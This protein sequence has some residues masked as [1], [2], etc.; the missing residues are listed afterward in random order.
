MSS[1]MILRL[2]MPSKEW[3]EVKV[4]AQK[5]LGPLN[6]I[7]NSI[8]SMGGNTAAGIYD[9]LVA[10]GKIDTDPLGSA[11]YVSSIRNGEK[12]L[13]RIKSSR[14]DHMKKSILYRMI[15]DRIA[16]S[17]NCEAA[18][19]VGKLF[20]YAVDQY[21]NIVRNQSSSR[22]RQAYREKNARLFGG[23]PRSERKSRSG[24]GEYRVPPAPEPQGGEGPPSEEEQQMADLIARAEAAEV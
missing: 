10:T 14:S 24:G 4:C 17:K 1:T 2:R 19:R 20:K 13:G 3:V 23:K 15:L 18:N 5:Q 8:Q 6:A 21:P 9:Y 22:G 12:E 7:A 16:E 11:Y